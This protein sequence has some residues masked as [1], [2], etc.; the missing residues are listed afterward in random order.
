MNENNCDLKSNKSDRSSK[1]DSENTIQKHIYDSFEKLKDEGI[2]PFQ[3]EEQPLI[4]GGYTFQQLEEMMEQE[5]KEK[6]RQEELKNKALEAKEE[7]KL[8]IPVM[9]VIVLLLIGATYNYAL[10]T[11]QY[12]VKEYQDLTDVPMLYQTDDQWKDVPYSGSNIEIAGCGPT[13]LSMIYI[14]MNGDLTYDP[15]YMARFCE[16]NNYDAPGY[17]TKWKVF[18][19]GAKKLGLKSKTIAPNKDL[20]EK[21]L[22]KGNPIV[23]VMG[24]GYFTQVGHFIVLAGYIEGKIVVNDPNAGPENKR[25][26]EFNTFKDQIKEMWVF[27]QP[28]K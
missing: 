10:G 18:S 5:E 28:E 14:Y 6:S 3:P 23:C 22:K 4:K 9:F 16:K 12:K 8:L 7:R 15:A 27:E 24:P 17:G 26:W 1:F 2:D 20:V 19:E 11:D 13:C 25:L 21:N